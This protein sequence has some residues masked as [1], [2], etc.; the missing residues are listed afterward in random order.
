MEGELQSRPMVTVAIRQTPGV[1]S[2]CLSAHTGR[3]Q[4]NSRYAGFRTDLGMGFSLVGSLQVG[5]TDDQGSGGG[6]LEDLGVGGVESGGR[7]L[8]FRAVRSVN[9][10]WDMRA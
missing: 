1:Q 6:A 8:H 3:D 5:L 10:R 7:S 4:E 2:D 9:P